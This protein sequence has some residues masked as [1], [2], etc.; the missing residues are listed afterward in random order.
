[1][2]A[3]FLTTVRNQ[4]MS[5]THSIHSNFQANIISLSMQQ[6]IDDLPIHTV[7][8]SINNVIHRNRNI[9]LAD[10]SF[11][12][13]GPIDMLIG[14]DLFWIVFCEGKTDL[15]KDNPYLKN[16]V[17]GWI[18]SGGIYAHS[19]SVCNLSKQL[20]IRNTFKNF[21]KLRNFITTR[22]RLILTNKP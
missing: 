17:F 5:L 4:T 19:V 9:T 13:P 20:S 18:V 11:H 14:A 2:L 8:I 10:P 7:D 6:I 16:S 21:G 22:P 12:E 15:S 1:M 3:Y